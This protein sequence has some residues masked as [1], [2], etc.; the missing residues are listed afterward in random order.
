MTPE[1]WQRLKPLYHA[2]L[3][4][5][6]DK[7]AQFVIEACGN[8]TELRDELAALLRANA[9]RP[10]ADE[11]A[12]VADL[13]QLF[14]PSVDSFAAGDLVLG[15]FRIV[16]NLG[17]GGM[18]EVYEAI[19][20]ELGKVALKTIRTDLA[21][22][23]DILARFKKEVQ[24]AR[25]VSGP[26]ICRIHE[27]FIVP[28]TRD[29][30]TRAFLTMEYLEG[31]TLAE[32]IHSSGPLPW[33]D[34]RSIALELCEGLRVIHEAGIVHRDLKSRNI[35]LAQRNAT[36]CAVLMDFGLA[37]EYAGPAS[38][39]N[40]D[41]TNPGAVVGTPDYMAPEQFE[42][43]P[44]SPATDI[45]ALGVVLYEMLTAEQPFAAATPVAAAVQRAK[46]LKPPSSLQP[47]LPRRWDGIIEKCLE[48][49]AEDR[50]KSVE[51]VKRELELLE[52]GSIRRISMPASLMLQKI[53]KVSPLKLGASILLAAIL[54]GS[55]LFG[56]W[57]LYPRKQ[58]FASISVEQ[59]TDS[60][61][62]TDIA[63]SPD[64]RT[65]AET[66]SDNGQ[67]SLWLRNI[68]TNVDTQIL[69]PTP[70]V[71]LGLTI[72]PDGNRIYYVRQEHE[73]SEYGSLYSVSVFGGTPR[74]LLHDLAGPVSFSR[75]GEHIAY[76]RIPRPRDGFSSELHLAD[77]EG[78]NDKTLS[79]NSG[80]SQ[81][82]AFSPDG[83]H[84][85]WA[86]IG[87][88]GAA[89]IVLDL[90][91]KRQQQLSLPD[92]V[93]FIHKVEWLPDSRHLLVNVDLP[94]SSSSHKSFGQFAIV[95]VPSG[96]FRR[97]TNDA[98][99]YEGLSLTA[100]AHTFGTRIVSTGSRVDYLKASNGTLWNSASSSHWIDY[101]NWSDDKHIA[102][103]EVSGEIPGI[104]LLDRDSG[105]FSPIDS[106][107]GTGVFPFGLA[108]CSDQIVFISSPP[109]AKSPHL[110][111]MNADSTGVTPI[112]G[113]EGAI[114]PSCGT[115]NTV[116]YMVQELAA[117]KASAWEVPLEGGNPRKIMDLPSTISPAYSSD[118]KIAACQIHSKGQWAIAIK[119]VKSQRTLRELNLNGFRGGDTL[120]FSRDDKAV[121]YVQNLGHELALVY[122]PVDGS[123]PHVLA[124]L[125]Q[126]KI[127]DFS[128]SPS[129]QEI[130]VLRSISRSDVALI[131]DKSVNAPN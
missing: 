130:A 27:L 33:Q 126:E 23:P 107:K 65:L 106:P 100:E 119:D 74:Q 10:T 77:R 72:S 94:N 31:T 90:K 62:I 84:V 21:D 9:S 79:K 52:S 19:D 64:G 85:A 56:I 123:A 113:T 122:V 40:T 117:G 2:A 73:D 3:D 49:R 125:G 39:A 50:F 115:H 51:E 118:G 13:K 7:R 17:S 18:G 35:M 96:E 105:K 46:R 61:D 116:R 42:G 14:D 11:T 28:R 99:S 38:S 5:P 29:T 26:N 58:P 57:R 53:R 6:E 75:D 69:L 70:L 32:K 109:S 95:S 97:V 76:M 25:T 36:R 47:K 43:K 114:E 98:A 63:L 91:S 121:V 88:T 83:S 86:Q 44:V 30:G 92:E 78:E 101:L 34:V 54:V 68:P 82:A 15:R 48:F 60:G 120:H 89:L 129:G 16:R 1:L 45:Y 112:S 111:R 12:P 131:S 66:K 104:T 108:I 8:D 124:K 128:W 4:I 71:Y 67:Y 127:K 22:T 87:R 24:L 103:I 59:I 102:M 81:N 93:L 41:F 110:A 55:A 20:I 80:L 37:R